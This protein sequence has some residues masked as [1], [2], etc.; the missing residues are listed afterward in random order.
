MWTLFFLLLALGRTHVGSLDL[1]RFTGW[2]LVWLGI[3][4]CTVSALFLLNDRWTTTPVAGLG[5]LAALVALTV[6]SV[7]LARISA[8]R[9]RA[10][11]DAPGATASDAEAPNAPAQELT[12][13]ST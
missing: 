5:A 10:D 1:G 4:T 12:P 7:G 11:S 6:L 2:F 13:A 8:P 3:P 9:A